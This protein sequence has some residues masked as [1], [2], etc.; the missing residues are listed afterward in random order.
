MF[1]NFEKQEPIFGHLPHGYQR[2]SLE[3]GDNTYSGLLSNKGDIQWFHPQP[4]VHQPDVD[5][6]AVESDIQ[7]LMS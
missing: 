7:E 5:L 2:F 1:K 3:I 6:K 4:Q